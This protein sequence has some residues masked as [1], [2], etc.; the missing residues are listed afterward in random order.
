MKY[1]VVVVEDEIHQQER[2]LGLLESIPEV[3]V[4]GVA[5]EIESAFGLINSIKPDLVF[6]DVMLPPDTGFDLLER[7]DKIRFEIIF[8]TSFQEYAVK[9]FRLSAVDYLLKPVVEEELRDA[10]QK[11]AAKK[12]ASLSGLNLDVLLDNLR[13]AGQQQKRIALPTLSGYVFVVVYDIVRCESDNTYTT[14]FLKDKRKIIVSKTLKD[15]ES[16]LSEFSFFRVHHSNLINLD[17]VLEYQKGEGGVV[18]MIDGASVDVSR[19]RKEEFIRLFKRIGS[20]LA[21]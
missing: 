6:L 4:S 21:H 8:T 2:L 3:V 18:K 7:F 19:R 1:K 9:A 20:S 5:P 15:C 12:G 16:L 13:S 10:I 17:H 11:F 14:F